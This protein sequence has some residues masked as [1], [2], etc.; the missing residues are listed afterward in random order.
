[1]ISTVFGFWSGSAGP[2][3]LTGNYGLKAD[4]A[5]WAL[6][7]QFQQQRSLSPNRSNFTSTTEIA[8]LCGINDCMTGEIVKYKGKPG[9]HN[10]H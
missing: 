7:S 1:M 8:I 5:W 10:W 2:F 3:S 6:A 4:S 9:K